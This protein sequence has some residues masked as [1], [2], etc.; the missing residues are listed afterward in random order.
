MIHLSCVT[1]RVPSFVG[2]LF[3]KLSSPITH[4]ILRRNFRLVSEC[5]PQQSFGPQDD[6][7]TR[8]I[9]G[10]GFANTGSCT[11]QLVIL[12]SINN[13]RLLSATKDLV[14]ITCSAKR[15]SSQFISLS[16]LTKFSILRNYQSLSEPEK[17]NFINTKKSKLIFLLSITVAIF[18]VLG[19]TINV[20][21]YNFVGAVFEMLWLP[22]I[23]VLFSL[24]VISIIYWIKD[25]FNI[26]SLY[27]YSFLLMILTMLFVMFYQ[28]SP[29]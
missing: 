16:L 7:G 17:M 20:Y 19:K 1:R 13:R 5:S 4:K 26:R 22:A 11:P 3:D 27:L 8:G 25:K 23:V 10:V 2:R 9:N 15:S 6:N 14:F 12:R 24:P 28:Q 29:A 18:W 21:H